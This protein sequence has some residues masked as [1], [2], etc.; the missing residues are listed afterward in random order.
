MQEHHRR[1]LAAHLAP[2]RQASNGNVTGLETLNGRNCRLAHS[3]LFYQPQ[4]ARYRVN[5]SR[6]WPLKVSKLFT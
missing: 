4:V 5:Q 2:G 1:S 6:A 3:T